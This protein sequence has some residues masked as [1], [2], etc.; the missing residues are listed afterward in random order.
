VSLFLR[1]VLELPL[2]SWP[3]SL[4]PPA[5]RPR[6]GP[7]AALWAE[8]CPLGPIFSLLV[9]GFALFL[10]CSS[11]IRPGGAD[12]GRL[13]RPARARPIPRPRPGAAQVARRGRSCL[14]C[15]GCF[16]LQCRIL[17]CRRTG[18][19]LDHSRSVATSEQRESTTKSERLHKKT[20]P[21]DRGII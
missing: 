9:R 4:A 19:S 17:Y 7:Q 2:G 5:L 6:G 21:S 13:G 10:P 18:R 12:R 3:S 16:C 20:A 8:G 11:G 14:K 1:V 15:C